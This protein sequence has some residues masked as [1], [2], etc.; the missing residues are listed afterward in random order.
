MTKLPR[1]GHAP[2]HLRREFLDVVDLVTS[3]AGNDDQD[4][5]TKRLLRLTG[6]LWNCTDILPSHYRR[7]IWSD[8]GP[9]SDCEPVTYAQ[10]SRMIREDVERGERAATS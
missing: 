2:D 10:A 4:Q 5:L 6:L 8:F 3:E 1:S 9:L 7:D